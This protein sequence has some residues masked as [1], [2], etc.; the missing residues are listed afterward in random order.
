MAIKK[1]SKEGQFEAGVLAIVAGK[2]W[3]YAA[4]PGEHNNWRLGIAIANEAGYHPVPEYWCHSDSLEEMSAHADELN[5]E[6]GLGGRRGAI[7]VASSMAA[8]DVGA[9]PLRTRGR[10]R[11]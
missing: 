10:A 8:A 6:L 5:E 4:V 7:I 3:A 2:T 1:F 11:G 9:M